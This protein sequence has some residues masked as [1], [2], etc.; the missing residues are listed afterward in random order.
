[1]QIY[2]LYFV[3]GPVLGLER[4]TTAVLALS[5]FQGAYTAEIFRAGLNSIAK[6]QFEAGQSLGAISCRQ[7]S[8]CHSAAGDPADPAAADQRGRIAGKKLFYCQRD[9]NL[10]PDNGRPKYR[11]RYGHAI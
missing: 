10:R 8:V 6:G 11:C 7:L 9:G 2:L 4:F 1:M 5:L 3:F